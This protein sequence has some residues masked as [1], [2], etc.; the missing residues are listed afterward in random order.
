[1]SGPPFKSPHNRISRYRQILI[2]KTEKERQRERRD[3]GRES[4]TEE[5][6]GDG[7]VDEENDAERAE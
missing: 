5:R 7:A 2:K 4:M 1:M 6:E 3:K